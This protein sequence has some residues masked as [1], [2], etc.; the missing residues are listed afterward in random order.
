MYQLRFLLKIRVSSNM[1]QQSIQAIHPGN[2]WL[3][4]TF[5][6][7]ALSA[8]CDPGSS[9]SYTLPVLLNFTSS[10]ALGW[11]FPTEEVKNTVSEQR[12]MN[13]VSTTPDP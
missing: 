2:N 3:G 5:R 11:V 7:A 4:P 13:A 1:G 6:R 10:L 8:P 9:L 12:C